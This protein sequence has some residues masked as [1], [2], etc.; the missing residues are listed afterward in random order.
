ME[1]KVYSRAVNKASMASSLVDGKSFQRLFSAKETADF[2]KTDSWVCCETCGKVRL[3]FVQ[4][5]VSLL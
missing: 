2:A 3:L 1:G 5:V 4:R